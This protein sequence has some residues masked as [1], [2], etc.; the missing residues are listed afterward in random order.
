LSGP[1]VGTGATGVHLTDGAAGADGE[2]TVGC[3]TSDAAGTAVTNGLYAT[4]TGVR[5]APGGRFFVALR[6]AH[7]HGTGA[8]VT[9]TV[10][11]VGV[12]EGRHLSDNSR[13]LTIS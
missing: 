11:A 7:V 2:G 3:F 10:V 12:D 8:V 4:C 13:D 9:V 1:A 6:V 5:T